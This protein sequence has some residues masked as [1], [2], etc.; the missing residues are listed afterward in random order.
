M[1]ELDRFQQQVKE[2][3][4]AVAQHWQEEKQA[5]HDEVERRARR[6]AAFDDE[7]RRLMDRVIFPRVEKVAELFPNATL[8]PEKAETNAHLVCQFD[9]TAEFPATTRLRVAVSPDA[10]I[11]NALVTYDLEIVPVY[12]EFQGHD[13]LVVP[14]GGIDERSV[15]DWIER[16]L[17]GFIDAYVQLQTLDQYQCENLVLDPVCQM[18]FNKAVAGAELL[19]E[20]RTYYFCVDECRRKFVAD[21]HRYLTASVPTSPTHPIAESQQKELQVESDELKSV[22]R[23]IDQVRA[24]FVRR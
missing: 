3:L 23:Q 24:R 18:R 10:D 20:G 9:K 1:Q 5:I 13:Q 22:G 6:L 2:K 11:K 21:P 12:F 17:L 7:E 16:K 14:V 4:T 19:Y 15:G 8:S